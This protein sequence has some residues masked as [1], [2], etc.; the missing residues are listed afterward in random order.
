ML[1]PQVDLFCPNGSEVFE[2]DAPLL[3]DRFELAAA[4]PED[5]RGF[6]L[7]VLRGMFCEEECEALLGFDG[8]ALP[9]LA[10]TRAE[11]FF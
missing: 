8:V 2:V 3:N 11:E 9:T 5:A 7:A 4:T 10:L 6:A 1:F